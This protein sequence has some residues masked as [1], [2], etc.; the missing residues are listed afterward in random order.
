MLAGIYS[1]GASITQIARNILGTSSLRLAN[2][3]GT[4]MGVDLH[5]I[6]GER[7][8]FITLKGHVLEA[9]H[10]HYSWCWCCVAAVK[11]IPVFHFSV[12]YIFLSFVIIEL[13]L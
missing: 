13:I 8:A 10:L 7:S 5:A 12:L 2:N 1:S 6:Y 9:M 11:R 4:S 3:I